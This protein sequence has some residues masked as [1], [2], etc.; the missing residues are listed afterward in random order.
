MWPCPEQ[1]GS[2][3][4]A[5][6]TCWTWWK[7]R[8][9]SP[10]PIRSG[11]G[12]ASAGINPGEAKIR[13]GLLHD[14]WPATF[15][16]GQGSDL[17]GVVDRVGP[18]VATV[19]VGDEVIGWTDERTGQADLVVVP[20][21]QTTPRP[22]DVPWEVAGSLFVAGSTAWATVQAVAPAPGD[23]VVV[24][25]AAGGVGAVTVQLVVRTGA[26]GD[27]PGQSPP[28]T[29]GCRTTASSPSRTARGSRSGSVTQR[30]MAS[31]PSSTC[32]ATA[33]STSRSA[34]G[35]APERINTIVD[36]AAVATH[37]VK[38]EGSAAG[39]SA[40][41][42]AALAALIA[43]GELDVPIAATYPLDRVRDAFRELAD[44]HTRGKIVLIP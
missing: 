7:C 4:T 37:G 2:T 44:G 28:T 31:T 13:Q 9:P 20:V 12:S 6:S 27:R 5:G 35:V 30:P 23:V 21:T 40:G 39:A 33:T 22:P 43:A 14:L 3:N 8:I 18:D 36:F 24:S 1:S 42:L 29:G 38:G 34:L 19:A 11:S 26:H 17:A 10:G 41:T 32:T 25:A 15:P 16:S